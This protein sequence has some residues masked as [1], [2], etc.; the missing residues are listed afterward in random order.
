MEIKIIE[1]GSGG[2]CFLFND[3]LIIDAGLSYKKISETVD[4]SKLKVVMLTHIHGDHFNPTTIRKLAVK[5][6]VKFICGA[7]L[8]D[9]LL[10]LGIE[11]DQIIEV[12][13]GKIYQ[14]VRYKIVPVIAYHDVDNFGYRI[15]DRNHKH[16]HITDTNSL[17][18]IEAK[19]YDSATIECNHE[20]NALEK[21]VERAEQN[22]EFT[23]LKGAKN[24]HLS[25]Q[26]ALDFVKRNRI[27]KLIPVHIGSSTEREVIDALRSN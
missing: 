21:L 2:N 26:K 13:S 27:K 9:R 17:E 1:T 14:V 19:D 10:D 12:K 15:I 24:S 23:H 16:F 5:H 8:I 20:I 7:F 18:G 4:L 3:D 6:N 11:K 22:G 25:V